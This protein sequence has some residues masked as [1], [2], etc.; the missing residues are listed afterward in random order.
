M[1]LTWPTENA[2]FEVLASLAMRFEANT[3]KFFAVFDSMVALIDCSDAE[4][5]RSGNFYAEK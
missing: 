3:S 5:L 2:Q 1:W 4:T